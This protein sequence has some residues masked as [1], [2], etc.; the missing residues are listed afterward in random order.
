V[1][2]KNIVRFNILLNQISVIYY[3]KTIYKMQF[4]IQESILGGRG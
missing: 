3:K 4:N 2:Y 1:F